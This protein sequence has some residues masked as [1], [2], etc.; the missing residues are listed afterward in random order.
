MP[1]NNTKLSPELTQLTESPDWEAIGC[2]IKGYRLMKGYSIDELADKL[3]IGRNTLEK[4]ESGGSYTT[5]NHLWNFIENE[6]VSILWLYTG[7]GEY[8][9]EDPPGLLPST[10]VRKRGAGIKP[11]QIR[12]DAE[13]GC[14]EGDSMEFVL[15]IDEYKRCNRIPFPSWTEVYELFLELGYRKV[16][17]ATI[18]PSNQ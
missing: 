13:Q 1:T 9:C 7:N 4:L 11:K 16:T 10:I 3:D 5:Q 18:N 17:R 14:Y 2:R 12:L 6:G 8:N 15:A